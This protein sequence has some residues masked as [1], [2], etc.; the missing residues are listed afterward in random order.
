MTKKEI[1]SLLNRIGGRV[2]DIVNEH[3]ENDQS[4]E[5]HTRELLLLNM[6]H[7][8]LA[9]EWEQRPASELDKSLYRLVKDMHEKW[10]DLDRDF[11][12]TVEGARMAIMN[13]L[14]EILE[15]LDENMGL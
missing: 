6:A 8:M 11:I 4:S 1:A 12:G 13:D 10:H 14:R 7:G 3:L 9:K 2:A 5:A 15:M